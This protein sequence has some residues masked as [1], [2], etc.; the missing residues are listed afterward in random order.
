MANKFK[1]IIK[2]TITFNIDVFFVLVSNVKDT[3][4]ILIVL[5]AFVYLK[6]NTKV[7]NIITV[8]D[9]FRLVILVINVLI[10]IR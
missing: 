8:E 1:T 3:P 7:T 10:F 2:R 5:T 9:R 6:L 4:I